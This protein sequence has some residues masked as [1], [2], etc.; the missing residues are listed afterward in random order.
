M[1][2]EED[3]SAGSHLCG[4][5]AVELLVVHVGTVGGAGVTQDVPERE[6]LR[7]GEVSVVLRDGGEGNADV[8]VGGATD[9]DAIRESAAP[10][11]LDEED[12]R[13]HR[14]E[15]GLGFHAGRQGLSIFAL[16]D[17]AAQIDRRGHESALR[18]LG[19]HGVHDRAVVDQRGNRMTAA[20][21][22]L[23][24][25]RELAGQLANRQVHLRQSPSGARSHVAR[26]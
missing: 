23:A 19:R 9:A 21:G 10:A 13:L 6:I 15:G 25:E 16:G 12:L 11:L 26:L 22:V 17:H 3:L 1:G 2:S 24:Q 8:G 4:L 7:N 18:D 14:I 5:L 20:E